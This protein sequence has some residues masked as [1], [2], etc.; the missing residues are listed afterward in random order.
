MT[1]VVRWVVP[2]YLSRP[3]AGAEAGAGADHDDRT[4]VVSR[5]TDVIIVGEFR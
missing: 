2:V 3:A 5:P 4:A 1:V